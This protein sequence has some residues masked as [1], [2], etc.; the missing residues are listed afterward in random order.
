MSVNLKSSVA[1]VALVA[2]SAFA[3]FQLDKLLKGGGIAFI[4]QKSGPQIN[5]QI[6]KLSGHKDTETAATKV[7]PII[8][9]GKSTAVGGAQ[10]LGARKNVDAVKA[11][12]QIEGDFLGSVRIKALIPIATD[13]PGGGSLSRV[14]GVGVSGILDI[15]L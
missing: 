9:I 1:L 3:G 5:G 4:I 15:R 2:S 14:E 10:V 13:R 6:N 8:S 7:V 12:A 11:V